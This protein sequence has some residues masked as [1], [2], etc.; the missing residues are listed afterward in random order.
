MH[1]FSA[2]EILRSANLN[3]NFQGLANGTLFDPQEAWIAPTFTNSW[4]NYDSAI[5]NPAGYM[6]DTLGFVHLRGLVKSG[7]A[8]TAIF[9]LPAGYRPYRQELFASLQNN[10]IGRI[11]VTT[12]GVVTHSLGGN[13]FVQL[14]GLTFK[15]YA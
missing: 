14:D 11:D 7:T 15:A 5:F 6:K 9:T 4:V 13:P 1:T 2:N 12:A 8:G 3:S 10:A